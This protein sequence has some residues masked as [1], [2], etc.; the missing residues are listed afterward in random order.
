M[1][2]LVFKKEVLQTYLDELGFSDVKLI[3]LAIRTPPEGPVIPPTKSGTTC[4]GH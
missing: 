4:K 3:K 2:E 1:A